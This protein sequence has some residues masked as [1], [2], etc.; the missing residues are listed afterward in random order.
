MTLPRHI[1][2]LGG[3][4]FVGR[5]LCNRLSQPSVAPSPM[6]TV[7]TRRRAQ[8][9]AV[10]TLPRV[11]L[12]E[13]DVFEPAFLDHCLQGV[14]AVVHLIAILHGSAAQFERVHAG[15]VEQLIQACDRQ[16]VRRLVHVSALG[17]GSQAPS[18]YLKSK[19]RA[20]EALHRS[21][22]DV[23]VLRPSVIFG[24]QDRFL[25]LFAD[26]QKVL[27]CVPLAGANAQFQPVWVEDVA[28]A[29]VECLHR[30]STMGKTYECAGPDVR[31]LGQLVRLAGEARGGAR[32]VVP[33]PLAVGRLQ[34]AVMEW[35]PGTPLM[36][37]DNIDSMRVPNIATGTLPGLDAL[38]I[39]A[40]A[41]DAI[42]PQYLG[43]HHGCQRFDPWRRRTP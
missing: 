40:S 22:L 34:A 42:V 10:Q 29:I 15:L 21:G 27:P 25:N 18:N 14:D 37:R 9:Q 16:G 7:P 4:G 1:V 2:I 19:H 17:V 28:Q 33:L 6:L 24:A 26:M 30:P 38:G 31:T 41:L 13:G 5:S 36:S 32:P 3:T 20:E 12:I 11:S 35:A 39:R 23:T 43:P 8:G